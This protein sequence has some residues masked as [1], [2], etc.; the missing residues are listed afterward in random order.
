MGMKQAS[1]QG[2]NQIRFQAARPR[3]QSKLDELKL[4]RLMDERSG[5]ITLKLIRETA[6]VCRQLTCFTGLVYSLFE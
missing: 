3:I 1:H 5:L 2:G 4:L 6:G